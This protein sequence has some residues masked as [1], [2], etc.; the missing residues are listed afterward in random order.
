MSQRNSLRKE[1][2]SGNKRLN[3]AKQDLEK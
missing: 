3:V 1:T 2:N